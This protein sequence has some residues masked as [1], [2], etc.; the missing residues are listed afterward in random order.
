MC[1][2]QNCGLLPSFPLALSENF[3]HYVYQNDT[4]GIIPLVIMEFM[5]LYL[6]SDFLSWSDSDLVSI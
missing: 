6:I 2:D 3:N 4:Y 5:E 1:R